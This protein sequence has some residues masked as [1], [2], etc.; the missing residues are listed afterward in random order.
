MIG[1]RGTREQRKCC[2]FCVRSCHMTVAFFIFIFY[3][4]TLFITFVTLSSYIAIRT[5]QITQTGYM[6]AALIM[7]TISSA[8]FITT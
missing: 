5:S 2:R 8:S 1:M 3:F 6:I 4:L 7:F